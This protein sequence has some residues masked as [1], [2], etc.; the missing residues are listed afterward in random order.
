[1]PRLRTVEEFGIRVRDVRHFATR[2]KPILL[3]LELLVH[4][5]TWILDYIEQRNAQMAREFWN[6]PRQS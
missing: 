3:D 1:M 6:P 4:G 2:L 5:K